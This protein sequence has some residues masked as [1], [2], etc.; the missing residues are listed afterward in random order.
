MW[1]VTL[2]LWPQVVTLHL[3][4]GFTTFC[5][6]LLLYLRINDNRVLNNSST[7]SRAV[8]LVGLT[9]V[10]IQVLLGGWLTSNYAAMACIELPFCELSQVTAEDFSSGFNLL[11]QIGPNYLGGQ[12]DGGARIAIHAMHR[13][14]AVVCTVTLL[15]LGWLVY[16]EGKRQL[17]TVL[18]GLTIAQI[19]L[20]FANVYFSLPLFNAVAH[21]IT[22]ALLVGFI[23]L[24]NFKLMPARKRIR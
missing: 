14:G 7:L 23:V 20:G 12:L 3:I 21:N 6:L 5:L 24:I 4:G 2:K 15:F 8:A 11:Q 22:G 10:G 9:V 1:T 18:F 17:S 13:I 19:G 16:R